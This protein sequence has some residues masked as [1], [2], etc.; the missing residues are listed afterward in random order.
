[1]CVL[2]DKENLRLLSAPLGSL[3]HPRL[4]EAIAISR[5]AAWQLVLDSADTIADGERRFEEWSFAPSHY[6]EYVIDRAA[7]NG[8]LRARW[9]E[10]VRD[11]SI[12]LDPRVQGFLSSAAEGFAVYAILVGAHREALEQFLEERTGAVVY[13]GVGGNGEVLFDRGTE[14]YVVLSE[15]EAFR[16][17][18]DR[19]TGNLREES[20]DRLLQYTNLPDG[21]TDVLATMQKGD[22]ERANEILAGIVDV[23]ALTDDLV[24]EVGYGRFIAEGVTEEFSEQRFGD[25]IIIRMRLPDDPD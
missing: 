19:V 6:L 7:T 20:P 23:E 25:R 1:M 12:L 3:S 4:A 24:R 16:I 14:R 22:D 17:A 8:A 2:C 15:E 11:G 13:A 9:I 18:V 10:S 5:E 21:A